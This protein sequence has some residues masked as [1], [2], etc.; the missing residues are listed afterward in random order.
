MGD[1]AAAPS[2]SVLPVSDPASP[3]N[4]VPEVGSP[5]P[6]GVDTATQRARVEALRRISQDEDYFLNEH[7]GFVYDYDGEYRAKRIPQAMF[8]FF[9]MIDTY[10]NGVLD[11]KELDEA[12]DMIRLAKKAKDSN[13]SEIKYKHL[14]KAIQ[15]V[16]VQWDK[17]NSGS[18]SVMELGKAAEDQ[19]KLKA[20][21]KQLN[22]AVLALIFLV[23]FLCLA[24]FIL[25]WAANKVD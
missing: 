10:Q 2:S 4:T 22:T 1:S 20:V 14:P 16:L 11:A 21:N 5:D 23:V 17:D 12:G 13:S 9:T 6:V 7:K 19:R 8:E 15:E 18:V 24:T 25:S 3:P